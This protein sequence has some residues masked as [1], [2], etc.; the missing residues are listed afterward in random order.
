MVAALKRPGLLR[1]ALGFVLGAGF[2]LALVVILRKV[3]GLPTWQTQQTGYP[4]VVVPSITASLG[5]LIGIGTAD[6]WLRWAIGAPTFPAE[7]E[8]ENHG[9]YSWRDYFKVNT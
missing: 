1:G 5:F 6:Y 4:Q 9:A 2:G 3:S 7:R 8:H